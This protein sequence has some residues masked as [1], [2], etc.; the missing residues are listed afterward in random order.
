MPK[1]TFEIPRDSSKPIACELYSLSTTTTNNDKA[2]A[3]SL[4]FTHGAGGTLSTPAVADF[5]SGYASIA[6]LVCFQGNMNLKSRVGMFQEV[7]AHY[8]DEDEVSV[9]CLGG[10]SMGARA[11]VMAAAAATTTE[12]SALEKTKKKTTKKLVLVS[13]PLQTA[14][15]VRDQ[16]L[17]DISEEVEV[18][19]VSGSRDAMCDLAKLDAVRN[20]MEAKTWRIVVKDADHG[21]TVKPKAGTKEVGVAVGEVVA[22]WVVEEEERDDEAVEGMVSWDAEKGVAVWS[23]WRDGIADVMGD[24][25]TEREVAPSKPKK[26]PA[27]GAASEVAEGTRKS[28]RKRTKV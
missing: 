14:K 22:R 15:E 20:K 27:K 8:E 6:P 12:E 13:Y 1:A 26:R 18:L 10:R 4:I 28:T 7:M 19:F 2:S 11:A 16:I 24:G 25:S 5:A 3:P 17:L 9:S 21:M 23:G